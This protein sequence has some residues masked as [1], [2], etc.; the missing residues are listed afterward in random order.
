MPTRRVTLLRALRH[1]MWLAVLPAFWVLFLSRWRSVG[2]DSAHAYWNAWNQHLYGASPGSPDA[3]SYS[4]VFAQILY[5][6]T[7]LPWGAFLV[8]WSA[9]L[10]VALLWLLWPLGNRWRWLVLA[11]TAPPAVAIGNIEPLLAVAAVIGITRPAAWAL[12]LLTKVTPGLGPLWFAMR[13]EWR[14]ALVAL[15]ATCGIVAVSFA[16]EPELWIAWMNFLRSNSDVQI[17]YLPLWVRLPAAVGILAWGARRD[18]PAALALAMVF[19]M[20]LWSS[21]VLLLLTAIPRLR[22]A[23]LSTPAGFRRSTSNEG[24]LPTSEVAEVGRPAN[25]PQDDVV[26]VAVDHRDTAA[27]IG[28]ATVAQGDCKP[29]C[30]GSEAVGVAEVDHCP[31]CT[32]DCGDDLG[33][34]GKQ[35]QVSADTGVPSSRN[36]AGVGPVEELLVVDDDDELGRSGRDAGRGRSGD[37]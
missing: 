27:G 8:V 17:R 34:A 5:P 26:H 14:K 2:L 18:R 37:R 9:L 30:K 25:L 7:L 33:P 4:P 19:A 16:L 36:P 31:P 22:L 13:R 28:T 23:S 10:C 35:A 3:Y 6:L 32:E 20:P 1:A 15:G 21:G 11:Y 29:Q 12:P 24:S